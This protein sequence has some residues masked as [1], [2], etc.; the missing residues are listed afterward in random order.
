MYW[1]SIYEFVFLL[2][3]LYTLA[4]VEGGV[5]N[6][7][8]NLLIW[9][10]EGFGVCD[11]SVDLLKRSQFCCFPLLAFVSRSIFLCLSLSLF[12]LL[13]KMGLP[14]IW[15]NDTVKRRFDWMRAMSFS[16]K[17]IKASIWGGE[18]GR[19]FLLVLFIII[20]VR[21]SLHIFIL[22]LQRFLNA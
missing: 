11:L 5:V 10:F 20:R 4:S 18:S 21:T 1:Y 8:C 19:L 12:N 9:F 7:P 17:N 15:V 13:F 6:R 22:D 2:K 16:V 3:A 14:W